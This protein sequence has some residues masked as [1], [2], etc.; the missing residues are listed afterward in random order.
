[1]TAG[2]SLDVPFTSWREAR[3]ATSRANDRGNFMLAGGKTLRWLAAGVW[4]CAALSAATA[5]AAAEVVITVDKATQRMT[6]TVDGSE[7]YAWAVSTGLAGGPPAGTYHP[8]RLE[9][10]WYSH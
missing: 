6:V 1:M 10:T 7:R 2:I 8:E 3:H 4:A 5:P 9:R